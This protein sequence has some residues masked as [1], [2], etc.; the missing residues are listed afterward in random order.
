MDNLKK[1][2]DRFPKYFM[3]QLTKDEL[4]NSFKVTNCDIKFCIIYNIKP[5]SYILKCIN[6]IVYIY[7]LIQLGD[8]RDLHLVQFLIY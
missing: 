1:N 4:D 5:Y 3:F 2:I 6:L 8:K 7:R